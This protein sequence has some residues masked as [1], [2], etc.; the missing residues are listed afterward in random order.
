MAL[1]AEPVLPKGKIGW[2]DVL[3]ASEKLMLE[4]AEAT[5]YF[6]RP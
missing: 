4:R 6:E 2:K 3:R 1:S 5:G